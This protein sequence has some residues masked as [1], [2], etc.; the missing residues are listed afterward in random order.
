MHLAAAERHDEA[1]ALLDEGQSLEPSTARQV[2][3]EW[4]LVKSGNDANQVTV[5]SSLAAAARELGSERTSLSASL[6]RLSTETA[7]GLYGGVT[8]SDRCSPQLVPAFAQELADVGVALLP[9]RRAEGLRLALEAHYLFAAASRMR[10]LAMRV[11]LSSFGGSWARALLACSRVYEEM[12]QLG[13]ALDLASWSGGLALQM[14]LVIG[15]ERGLIRDCIEQHG[16]MLIA[17][18]DRSGGEDV[19]RHAAN[20]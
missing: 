8:P 6:T 10:T 13:M 16:R 2:T 11:N 12:G 17:T 14:M 4:D 19:L 5:A 9:T 3:A 1:K 7:F 18:G 15:A 20:L